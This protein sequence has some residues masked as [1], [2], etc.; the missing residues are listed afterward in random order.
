MDG[1]VGIHRSAPKADA[2]AGMCLWLK[3]R[4]LIGDLLRDKQEF[5]PAELRSADV[6]G[7]GRD[8]CRITRTLYGEP[9]S[10]YNQ[11]HRAGVVQWQYRSFPSF[12]YGFDS[13]RPLQILKE[14]HSFQIFPLPFPVSKF[15]KAVL[16]FV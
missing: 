6:T 15:A 13:R 9:I 5:L 4:G 3:R 12:R 11:K 1:V 14:L 8:A 10:G 7:A 16:F 2:P